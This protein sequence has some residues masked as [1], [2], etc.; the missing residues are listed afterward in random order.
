MKLAG[1]C[2]SCLLL[3]LTLPAKSAVLYVNLS[4]SVPAVPFTS[5]QTAATNI[6]DAID[7][8]IA[9]DFIFVSNG[10]YR[11]GGRVVYGNST[12][13]LVVDKRLRFKALTDPA[14][15]ASQGVPPERFAV[16]T[17]PT[18]LFSAASP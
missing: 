2:A 13:R 1:P 14:R 10:V 4:N 5:W 3:L 7:A 17:W 16:F 11:T 15:R 6:Q 9:G 12:N 8:A 18:D